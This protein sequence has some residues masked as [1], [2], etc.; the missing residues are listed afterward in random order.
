MYDDG[1]QRVE[2]DHEGGQGTSDGAVLLPSLDHTDSLTINIQKC[3]C[4]CSAVRA[5]GAFD[6]VCV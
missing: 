3:S 5:Y 6:F 2:E 4:K 1:G